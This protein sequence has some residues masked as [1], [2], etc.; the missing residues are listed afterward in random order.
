MQLFEILNRF[1]GAV[2]V[3]AEIEC[4][5]DASYST[6]WGL[7]VRWAIQSEADLS[8]ADLS[9]A[10][11]SKANLSRADL[12][13]AD[14]SRANLSWA[15][16]SKAN[17]SRADLSWADLSR[18]DLSKADLSK[19]NLSRADLSEADLSR[20]NLSWADLSKAN[21]SRADLSWA[22]LSRA[23][24][25]W[26]NLS[27]ANLSWANLS[28]ANLSR[29]D[30]SEAD[31]QPVRDDF[32]A[33]LSAAPAEV[34]G[35]RAAI[36]EGRIDGSN[37][38]GECACLVGT[39]AKVANCKF[40]AIEGLRPNS[41]RLAERFFL[42]IGEGDTPETNQFSKLALEWTD[43]WLARMKVAFGGQPIADGT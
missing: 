28:W 29:A 26:A 14:L 40:N 24:L 21:L 19:A 22:D 25:S 15:D 31:L 3:T 5:D 13:E 18:A 2:Q 41:D 9:K 27:W 16:L 4:A 34:E 17:L 35:L 32:Y 37:Y 20:A 23:D 42:G 33:V 39:I 36:A 30:L 6:K 11:L 10:D 8:R 1:T 43:E 38:E 12:S 7:A